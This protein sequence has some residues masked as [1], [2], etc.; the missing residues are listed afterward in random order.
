MGRKN[1][2]EGMRDGK[3]SPTQMEQRKR[4]AVESKVSQKVDGAR[5]C[6]IFVALFYLQSNTANGKPQGVSNRREMKD[7]NEEWTEKTSEYMHVGQ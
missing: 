5:L 6:R 4:K 2:C 1:L 3:K 7:Y